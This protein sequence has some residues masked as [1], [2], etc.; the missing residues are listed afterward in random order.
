MHQGLPLKL[1][2]QQVDKMHEHVLELQKKTSTKPPIYNSIFQSKL[3]PREPSTK[4]KEC[5]KKHMTPVKPQT[6][7]ES[8]NLEPG[9]PVS[10]IHTLVTNPGEQGI[11]F[12]SFVQGAHIGV[13]KAFMHRIPEL[14]ENPLDSLV[15]DVEKLSISPSMENSSRRET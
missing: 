12:D 7:T 2:D 1:T 4:V 10:L 9:K 8:E 15:R 5:C 3:T 11:K 13:G 6:I 14:L